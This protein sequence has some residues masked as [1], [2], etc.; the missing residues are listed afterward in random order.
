MT[1]SDNS[2]AAPSPAGGRDALHPGAVRQAVRLSFAQAMLGA[3]YGASTGGM[4]LIG[5]ALLLGATNVQIGLMS[6]IP[7]LCIGVQLGTAALIERGVSRR[8]LTVVAALLNVAC[9]VLIILIPY[10]FS[11]ASASTRVS[12]LIAV[13]TAVTFFAY[14]SGNARGSWVGDLIPARFRGTFFGRLAMYGGI[15]ASVFAIGEGAFLDVVKQHGLAAFSTLFGFGMLFG[16]ANAVLFQPQADV[17]APRHKDGAHLLPM[18]REA[19]S[20]HELMLVMFFAICWSMQSVAG[21]FYA[22]YMLRDLK[23]P[24]VGVGVLNACVMLAFLVSSP[25]W[26]RAID[27]W[28]C[29]P[30]LRLSAL[31][32]GS[33]QFVWLGLSSAHAVFCV[34]PIVNLFAGAAA[35]GVSVALNTL[36]YKTTPSR[37]RSV[38]FAIYSIVVTLLTAPLPVLGGYL[39][40]WL[41]RLGLP[42]DLRYTFYLAG[43]FLLLS[44][45]MT[46]GIHEP[47]A[48]QVRHLLRTLGNRRMKE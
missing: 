1:A 25:F 6:T 5:Y 21:P 20:N 35:G 48:Y 11:R 43:C 19:F 45:V 42:A 31:V 23:M 8:W 34:I 37:G 32:L 39:P 29:R 3:V 38:Q 26:G 15:V 12:L 33:L 10:A 4:F 22:T 44:V 13:I 47:G 36:L 16:I 18:V 9:W 24:F 17:P 40:A 41:T 28:G 7:M 30:V 27:R 2:T 46:Y 14:I